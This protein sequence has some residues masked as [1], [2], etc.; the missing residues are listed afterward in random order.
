MPAP[1]DGHRCLGRTYQVHRRTVRQALMSAVPPERKGSERPAPVLGPREPLTRT[2][3]TA[4]YIPTCPSGQR[5]Q[6]AAV[7]DLLQGGR[8]PSAAL[9]RGERRRHSTANG[10]DLDGA[11]RR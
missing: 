2:W 3:V 10:S 9:E 4:R 6:D 7:L 5:N 1:T 8:G 11:A